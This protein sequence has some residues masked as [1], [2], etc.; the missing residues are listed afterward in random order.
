MSS[1]L[2]VFSTGPSA[3][4]GLLFVHVYTLDMLCPT[5]CFILQMARAG[6]GR[7]RKLLEVS[8]VGGRC[9]STWA[10]CCCFS[11]TLAGCW[12]ENGA[13]GI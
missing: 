1:A 9:L 4:L 3:R 7:G 6:T 8:H 5:H 2:E 12:M 11:D 13:A 10:I